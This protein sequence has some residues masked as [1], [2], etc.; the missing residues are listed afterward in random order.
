[1]APVGRIAEMQ[2]LE[3]F[4]AEAVNDGAALLLS[5][6]PGVGKTLLLYAIAEVAR[7]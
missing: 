3:A 2:R 5:G 7:A 6:E 1:M 4:L